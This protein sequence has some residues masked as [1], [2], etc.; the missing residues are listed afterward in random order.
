MKIDQEESVLT[1]EATQEVANA[2]RRSSSFVFYAATCYFVIIQAWYVLVPLARSSF[3]DEAL[4]V[5]LLPFAAIIAVKRGILLSLVISLAMYIAVCFAGMLVYK[6]GGISQP[7]SA[8]IGAL[9]DVK[10]FLTALGF[11][12]LF[13]V[14][15]DSQSQFD[16]ICLVFIM[17]AFA[18]SIFVIRDMVMSNGQSIFGNPLELRSGFFQPQGFQSYKIKSVTISILGFITSYYLARQRRSL[19]LL[20]VSI[21]LFFISVAHL[22][23]KETLALLMMLMFL[24][25]GGSR[26]IDRVLFSII[27]GATVLTVILAFTPLG[28]V[29][30][31][32]FA[33]FYGDSATVTARSAILKASGA[34]ASDHFPIGS[35]GGTFASGPS[36]QGGYSDVYYRYG[37]S[38]VWGASPRN[39]DFLQDAFWPKVLGESGILGLMFY[40]LAFAIFISFPIRYYILSTSF[41]SIPPICFVILTLL[42][43]T[44]SSPFTDD[45][46]GFLLSLFVGFSMNEVR[47]IKAS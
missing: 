18:N 26:R 34:I 42:S 37:L 29:I 25:P 15:R 14:A 22:S 6:Y 8:V 47:R 7:T 45:L 32:R 44:G 3:I 9:S 40:L 27:T 17:V 10:P 46:T 13:S 28:S 2:T 16:R 5:I 33:F 39:P 43:S 41:R 36:Y 11:C 19:T 21:Y 4:L 12:Y 23:A 30:T 38:N 1:V 35:G 20:V 24:K 31:D